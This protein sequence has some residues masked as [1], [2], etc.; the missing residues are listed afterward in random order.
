MFLE[1]FIC[2]RFITFSSSQIV[3]I[4]LFCQHVD[5]LIISDLKFGGLTFVFT[6]Y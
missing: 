4:I 1:G 6:E 5:T 3:N 2:E